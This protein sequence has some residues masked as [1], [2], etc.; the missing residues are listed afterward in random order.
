[1]PALL[2]ENAFIPVNQRIKDRI[3]VDVHQIA[4]IFIIHGS[5]GIDR[6]VRISHGV[7]ESV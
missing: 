6:L 4:E 3:Q 1:M 7:E 2:A 5:H